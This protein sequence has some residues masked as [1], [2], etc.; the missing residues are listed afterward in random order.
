MSTRTIRVDE[1]VYDG[2]LKIRAKMQTDRDR[3][4]SMNDAVKEAIRREE[5]KRP[6]D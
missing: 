1:R 5:R 3:H 4:V 6:E 2:L